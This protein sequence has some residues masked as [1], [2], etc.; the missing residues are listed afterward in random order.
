[1]PGDVVVD[2]SL[3]LALVMPTPFSDAA[4]QLFSQ[5]TLSAVGVLAPC[6]WAYEICSA[7]RQGVAVG[8][9]GP[10]EAESGLAR[11]LRLN[12]E[13]I[14][15]NPALLGSGLHLAG[16]VGATAAYDVAYLALALERGAELWTADR[17]LANAG[18]AAGFGWVRCPD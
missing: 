14:P 6:L 3:G 18:Q 12:I 10:D 11:L 5:W 15:P 7:L 13:L 4:H 8:A 17:R 2:A 1:M 16:R 9:L